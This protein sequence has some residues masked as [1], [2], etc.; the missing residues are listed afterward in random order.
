MNTLELEIIYFKENCF[1]VTKRMTIDFMK[2]L[3]L[4]IGILSNTSASVL[5]KYAMQPSRKVFSLSDPVEIIKNWPLWLCLVMYGIAFLLYAYALKLF[6]LNVAHPILTSGAIACVALSSFLLFKEQFSF[7]VA[8]GIELI[9]CGVIS[10]T[11]K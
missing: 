5:I 11:W 1:T 8:L 2:W 3:V 10:I 4:I 9:V 6:P 7:S